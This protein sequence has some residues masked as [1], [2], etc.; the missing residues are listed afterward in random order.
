MGDSRSSLDPATRF[1]RI[2]KEAQE[3]LAQHKGR[4]AHNL[5]RKEPPPQ[6]TLLLVD[7]EESDCV[8]IKH[9]VARVCPKARV[10][11]AASVKEA[12][13]YL[14]EAHLAVLD[15]NLKPGTS[16]ELLQKLVQRKVPCCV[17][18]GV[19]ALI[20]AEIAVPIICKNSTEAVEAWLRAS[21]WCRSR[22]TEGACLPECLNT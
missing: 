4:N 22:L 15:W 8:L 3:I 21:L 6:V 5:M 19:L 18:T 17:Y 1:D 9:V 2:L 11:T 13:K 16:A 20:P 14:Q 7:D 10:I 12:E